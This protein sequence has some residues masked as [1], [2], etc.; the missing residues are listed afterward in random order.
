MKRLLRAF[1][2]LGEEAPQDLIPTGIHPIGL[3][4]ECGVT[5]VS[6]GHR[7]VVGLAEPEPAA[8]SLSKIDSRAPY[9]PAFPQVA[10]ERRGVKGCV[11]IRFALTEVDASSASGYVTAAPV[12]AVPSAG[13]R[14][15]PGNQGVLREVLPLALQL[16]GGVPGRDGHVEQGRNQ[17]AGTAV[18]VGSSG[19]R[20]P[21]KG[22]EARW[23]DGLSASRS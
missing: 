10:G 12:T 6:A 5:S 15:G 23:V 13:D 3:V 8:S 14:Y 7:W 16:P 21:A 19:Y 18:S 4:P 17:P 1:F 22:R 11:L 9:G 20:R 2:R